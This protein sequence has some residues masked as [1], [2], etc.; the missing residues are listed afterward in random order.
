MTG[1]HVRHPVGMNSGRRDV[2]HRLL[3]QVAW[4][5]AFFSFNLA[6]SVVLPAS[7]FALLAVTTSAVFMAIA[8]ARAWAISSRIV[9]STKFRLS[10]PAAIS[11]KTVAR[12]SLL[13]AGVVAIGVWAASTTTASITITLQMVFLAIALIV[14]DLPRQSLIFRS[15]HRASLS[16]SLIYMFLGLLALLA[17]MTARWNPVWIW[18]VAGLICCSVAWSYQRYAGGGG[19]SLPA[20]ETRSHAWRIAAESLYTSIASQLALLLLFWFTVPEVTAGYRLSYAL[21]F[22]PAFM[23]LQGIA[24]LLTVKFAEEI[25]RTGMAQRKFWLI[26]PALTLLSATL[27]GIA[28]WGAILVLPVPDVFRTMLP[29]LLPVGISL[30]GAQILE[31]LLIGLRYFASEHAMHRV[32]IIVVTLDILAQAFGIWFNGVDGLIVALV[33]T[34]AIKLSAVGVVGTAIASGRFRLRVRNRGGLAAD[35]SRA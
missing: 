35:I 30:V 28:G 14:A 12:T 2:V 6:A 33:A 34:A 17:A 15:R 27:C 23:L 22:A 1:R 5:G 19:S 4:S 7:H 31:F 32:R 26:G 9:V 18:T 24:P 20:K 11:R 25:S 21:V 29:F 13:M 8:V 16:V 3:D 10:V